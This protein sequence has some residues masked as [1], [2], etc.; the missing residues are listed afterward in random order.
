VVLVLSAAVDR[1]AA[2]SGRRALRRGRVGAAMA[3]LHLGRRR[4]GSRIVALLGVSV[5][6]LS[7]AA[8]A[9][10]TGT[11][12]RTDQVVASLGAGRVV[13]VGV[14]SMRE[15]LADVRTVDPEG[16][17]AMAVMPI[18]VGVPILAVDSPRLG[19]VGPWPRQGSSG[20]LDATA[21]RSAL[22]PQ[23]GA[24]AVVTG[25]DLTATV[26]ISP[27]S[28]RSH[29]A[30]SFCWPHSTARSPSTCG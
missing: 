6:L 12:A 22:R 7:Y 3:M 16:R 15:L 18:G 21:V 20:G 10:G 30:S 23:A 19:V 27:V 5:G 4:T 28:A 11:A 13:S 9:F 17:Y 1:F 29:P 8:I 25:T 26:A 2:W 24:T 14:M